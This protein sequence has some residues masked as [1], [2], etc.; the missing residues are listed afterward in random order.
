M[1]QVRKAGTHSEEL[2]RYKF[3][4]MTG[5]IGANVSP[6]VVKARKAEV[7]KKVAK[8]EKGRLVLGRSFCLNC[9]KKGHVWRNCD[10]P[11]RRRCQA[12]GG[13]G[14]DAEKCIPRRDK[15]EPRRFRRRS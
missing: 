15:P 2:C 8:I 14:H 4:L 7:R 9:E 6:M 11:I 3:K 13:V 1:L 5:A 12:C 10:R